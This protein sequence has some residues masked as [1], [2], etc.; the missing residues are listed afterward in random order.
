VNTEH[1]LVI[2][3]EPSNGHGKPIKL[4]KLGGSGPIGLLQFILAQRYQMNA[5][6]DSLQLGLVLIYF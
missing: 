6:R 4:L 3:V 5:G 1:S 2:R